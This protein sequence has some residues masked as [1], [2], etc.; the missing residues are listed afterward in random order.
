MTLSVCFQDRYSA[1]IGIVANPRWEIPFK[2]N[3]G[4]HSLYMGA[5]VT[6]GNTSAFVSYSRRGSNG[7]FVRKSVKLISLPLDDL[8]ASCFTEILQNYMFWK[9]QKTLKEHWEKKRNGSC[10]QCQARE[11]KRKSGPDCFWSRHLLAT[12]VCVALI[13]WS[14]LHEFDHLESSTTIVNYYRKY[15][16]R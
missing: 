16:A 2:K 7:D 11:N 6:A 9:Q 10:S 12:I 15:I 4:I 13:G 3:E 14:M 1:L 8:S 5:Q